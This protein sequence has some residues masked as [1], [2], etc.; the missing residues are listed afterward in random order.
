MASFGT[1]CGTDADCLIVGGSNGACTASVCACATG[2]TYD[3]TLKGCT[4]DNKAKFGE[5]CTTE[6]DCHVPDAASEYFLDSFFYDISDLDF[7]KLISDSLGICNDCSCNVVS[8]T[9]S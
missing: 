3:S 9:V 7:E 5:T 8:C 1:A 4:D 2:Y 6:A